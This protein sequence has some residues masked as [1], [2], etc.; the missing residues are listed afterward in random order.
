MCALTGWSSESPWPARCEAQAGPAAGPLAPAALWMVLSKLRSLP[1]P[2]FTAGGVAACPP[3]GLLAALACGRHRRRFSL[4]ALRAA[5]PRARAWILTAA[6]CV[7]TGRELFDAPASSASPARAAAGSGSAFCC[8][9]SAASAAPGSDGL[10]S[11]TLA[12][13][14]PPAPGSRESA[15]S[16]ESGARPACAPSRPASGSTDSAPL[17]AASGRAPASAGCGSSSIGPTFAAAVAAPA[18]QSRGES[19]KRTRPDPPLPGEAGSGAEGRGGSGEG[20]WDEA[21]PPS[22]KEL[23]TPMLDSTSISGT[24]SRCRLLSRSAPSLAAAGYGPAFSAG[25]ASTAAPE[26]RGLEPVP[27]VET[28]R[29][30][31]I[32]SG[33]APS[34]AAIHAARPTF[35]SAPPALDSHLP[36]VS[37]SKS[38]WQAVT[39]E[40]MSSNDTSPSWSLSKSWNPSCA[41]MLL[42]LSRAAT[43]SETF[44]TGS[45]VSKAESAGTS[46]PPR[47]STVWTGAS[48]PSGAAAGGGADSVSS[49]TPRDLRM[50]SPCPAPRHSTQRSWSMKPVL[51]ESMCACSSLRSAS[52]MS[53]CRFAD[54]LLRSAKEIL[55]SMSSSK[56]WKPADESSLL[57]CSAAEMVSMHAWIRGIRIDG[58]GSPS[59][60]C[61]WNTPSELPCE[62]TL[63]P[64][65]LITSAGFATDSI[66]SHLR[67]SP[68]APWP[69][70]RYTC[71]S[72]SAARLRPSLNCSDAVARSVK[73]IDP[74]LSASN[75][76]YP[77]SGLSEL[78]SRAA[79]IKSMEERSVAESSLLAFFVF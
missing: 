78:Y 24:S 8:A 52:E 2:G 21:G 58:L 6:W 19:A 20:L 73:E 4:T 56:A 41:D 31:K 25:T 65:D 57:N 15:A 55:P 17:P 60:P 13:G 62:T 23:S 59:I 10:A 69:F 39:V 51:A 36:T 75:E 63:T 74:S 1:V 76:E 12:A 50:L 27:V 9:G 11:S 79:A 61:D 32:A 37:S 66:C 18:L 7:S 64:R 45:L 67:R 26:E 77:S 38:S 30:T 16:L 29:D 44:C 47:P 3:C 53:S 43:W 34:S 68:Y 54:T 72:L 14:A 33:R 22:S 70:E 28:P 40:N 49:S 71:T 5:I 46:A 48:P 42:N 35:S